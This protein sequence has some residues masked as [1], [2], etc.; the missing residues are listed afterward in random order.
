MWK[1]WFK[2]FTIIVDSYFLENRRR[3]SSLNSTYRQHSY[4]LCAQWFVTSSKTRTKIRKSKSILSWSMMTI[5]F[6]VFTKLKFENMSWFFQSSTIAYKRLF[7]LW[8]VM[9]KA[10]Q[11]K[12]RA[13]IQSQ[14]DARCNKKKCVKMLNIAS[15][16]DDYTDRLNDILDI[17]DESKKSF[18][19][20]N[21]SMIDNFFD[22]FS[23]KE[24]RLFLN[25]S[26]DCTRSAINSNLTF[27]N[28]TTRSVQQVI[29]D[30]FDAFIQISISFTKNKIIN[31]S[32]K[33]HIDSAILITNTTVNVIKYLKI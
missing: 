23:K 4:S 3:K 14:I 10:R 29:F 26:F 30:T 28:D 6:E 19:N 22:L 25:N 27:L 8:N 12:I 21:V 13:H 7:N 11:K 5:R 20:Q 32:E 15:I 31:I 24:R 17:S 9:S 33:I 1:R 18:V 16:V 2:H